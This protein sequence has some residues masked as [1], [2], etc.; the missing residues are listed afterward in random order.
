VSPFLVFI[1]LLLCV[2]Y[3]RQLAAALTAGV[4]VLA[5]LG[6]IYLLLS[7]SSGAGPTPFAG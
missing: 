7:V 1:G 2:A 3:W 4:V 6:V 5:V